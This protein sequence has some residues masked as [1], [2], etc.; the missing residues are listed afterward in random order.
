MAVKATGGGILLTKQVGYPIYSQTMSGSG[1]STVNIPTG[2]SLTDLMV[3]SDAVQEISLKIT[4]PNETE[5]TI[6]V[7]SKVIVPINNTKSL[8]VAGDVTCLLFGYSV[9]T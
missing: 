9:S 6:K 5:V 8:K 1:Y 3:S 7:P 4:L 2:F